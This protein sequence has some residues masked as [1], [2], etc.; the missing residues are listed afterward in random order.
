MSQ[1]LGRGAVN[2]RGRGRGGARGARAR[3]ITSGPRS[4][5]SKISEI[6][7]DTFNVGSAKFVA[8]FQKSRESTAYYVQRQIGGEEGYYAAQEI[9]TGVESVV[10]VPPALGDNATEDDRIIR[11]V[12]VQGVGKM[13]QKVKG[14]QKT[15][16]SI[17]YDQCS[18]EIKD[19]LHAEEG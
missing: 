13:R 19:K 8:Q 7:Y 14:A 5:K 16:F 18:Q 1:L 6:E 11:T 15:A 10:P 4:F 12:A 9:R 17:L 3:V 2:A